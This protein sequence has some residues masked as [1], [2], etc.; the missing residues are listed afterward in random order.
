MLVGEDEV[1]KITD[2]GMARDVQEEDIYIR[3]H[4]VQFLLLLVFF[5]FF[6][7][8]KE[9]FRTKVPQPILIYRSYQRYLDSNDKNPTQSLF[10]FVFSWTQL[11]VKL[12]VSKKCQSRAHSPRAF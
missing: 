6:I 7:K 10:F 1:C 2:F 9:L 8:R 5:F 4:E 11:F 3:T 12:N